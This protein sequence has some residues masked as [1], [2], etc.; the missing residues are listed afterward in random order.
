MFEFKSHTW[1]LLAFLLLLFSAVFAQH[2][3]TPDPLRIE[4]SVRG[5]ENNESISG[6][7]VTTDKGAFT[8]TNA[9]GE[10]AIE[11][12]IGD[13]LIFQSPDFETVRHRITTDENI[14]VLVED[15]AVS[16][17]QRQSN[18]R[19]LVDHAKYLDSAETYKKTDIKKSIDYVTRSIA[20]LGEQANKKALSESFTKLGEIYSF[21]EQYDL[22]ISSLEDAL[23]NRKSVATALLLAEA[24]VSN[25]EF[26]Q[27]ETEYARLTQLKKMTPAQRVRLYEG[28]GNAALG[29][30]ETERALRFYREA[31][32]IAEKN[33]FTSE[34]IDLNSKIGDTYATENRNIEAEG[35]YD[36][37]LE[38]SKQQNPERAIQESDKVADFYRR[39]NRYQDEIQL[40]KKNLRDLEKLPNKSFVASNGISSLDS[41]T[42]QKINYEIANAYIAQ[43]QLSEAIP[44]LEKSIVQANNGNDL[45][46]Q[47]DATRKLSE[48]YEYQGDFN[49]A[50]ST[51]QA[52][53]KLVDSLYAL[54]EQEISRIAR[55]NRDIL[56]KQN[57]IAS[58]EQDRELS[59]SKY[60]LAVTEQELFEETTRRQQWVIYSLLLGIA[61]LAMA[62][63]FFYRSG[64]QQKLANNLLALKSLRSQMN[65]HFIFN[66]LNSVNNYIAQSDER[67]ANRYLSDFSVLMRSVLENSEEDFIPL[68]KELDLLELYVKLEHSR[69]PDKFDY[70]LQIDPAIAIESFQIPP[71]LLQPYIEN[72]IWHGLRYR[73]EK[74][75]LKI[76]AEQIDAAVLRIR[77]ADNGIGRKRSMALKTKNQM[78]Q[79]SKGMGNIKKRIAILNDMYKNK[80]D[81]T[82]EDLLDDGTGTLVVLNLKKD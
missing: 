57:R 63:Y 77:I 9:L 41:I 33:Q 73:E 61:L 42:S 30:G 45:V 29:K 37:S 50:F 23:L 6:V 65:P 35:Y 55:L 64:Q 11:A 69:F 7:E 40:R 15:Y 2:P 38:L 27:A 16:R 20:V 56:E 3:A 47:K 5:K 74:G 19:S 72:A 34:I 54:K 17:K 52:Y 39:S 14:L 67:S 28:Q 71:M 26:D 82:I 1:G 46:I 68:S 78:R 43:D 32:T 10:F 80:I 36:N 66:A 22:A 76:E 8:T 12:E 79:K 48:V 60:D 75:Y 4:G 81:V 21:H 53:V 31:L 25:G 24:F 51:Y 49:R 18:T 62:V 70:E 13:L 58:L 44:Y 59:Q